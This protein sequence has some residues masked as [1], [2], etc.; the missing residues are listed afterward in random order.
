MTTSFWPFDRLFGTLVSG[1]LYQY[2]NPDDSRVGF[3]ACFWFS[4]GACILATLLVLRVPGRFPSHVDVPGMASVT[5]RALSFNPSGDTQGGLRCG[6]C[7]SLVK[8]EPLDPAAKGV[9][10]EAE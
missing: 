7:L 8:G 2:I 9:A 5:E 10:I 1:A 3:A 6:S 4:A